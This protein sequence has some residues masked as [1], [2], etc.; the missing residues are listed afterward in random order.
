[1]LPVMS[2][3]LRLVDTAAF[4]VELTTQTLTCFIGRAT[5]DEATEQEGKVKGNL[6]S[7]Y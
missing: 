3:A 5:S 7:S 4:S 6:P 1:M 2:T